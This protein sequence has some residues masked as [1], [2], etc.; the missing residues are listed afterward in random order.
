MRTQYRH[1]VNRLAIV[2][3]LRSNLN[4]CSLCAC[5][6]AFAKQQMEH[7][8]F[9]GVFPPV[10]LG[11]LS[12]LVPPVPPGPGLGAYL[13]CTCAS[14]SIVLTCLS[15]STCSLASYSS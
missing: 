10:A 15:S 14:A 8:Y 11:I 3:R 4:G 1:V 12:C 2:R 6:Y 5:V 9:C 13:A 7:I